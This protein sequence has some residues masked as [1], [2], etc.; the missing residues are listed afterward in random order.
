[1]PFNLPEKPCQ[2]CGT[3]TRRL[4]YCE[5]CAKAKKIEKIRESNYARG[6]HDITRD[7]QEVD[8]QRIFGGTLTW[9]N[10]NDPYFG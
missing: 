9:D 8:F 5:P 1:M 2:V 6:L 7:K 3:P 4:K 10:P